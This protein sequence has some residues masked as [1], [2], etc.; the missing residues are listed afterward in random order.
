MAWGVTVH[1]S[2]QTPEKVYQAFLAAGEAQM[3]KGI[4]AVEGEIRRVTPTKTG[5]LRR[6]ITSLVTRHGN[7][8]TGV[9]GT[10]IFYGEYLEMGTGLYGPLHHLIV[11]R[12]AKALRFPMPGSPN[13][14]LA[15]R[16]RSGKAGQGA[17]YVF[18][19][20]VKGIKPRHFFT[21]GMAAGLPGYEAEL[22]L[23]P[24]VARAKLAA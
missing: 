9:I 6:S 17:Q 12:K 16:Q 8:I 7:T 19:R 13:F 20:S 1:G 18:V 4:L 2:G 10:A 15:G 5:L 22:A 21:I 14:T 3:R 24:D 23:I 11:P